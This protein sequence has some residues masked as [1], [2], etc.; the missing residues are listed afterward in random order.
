M[1]LA[2]VLAGI[3]LGATAVAG[4]AW[5]APAATPSPVPSLSGCAIPYGPCYI[6]LSTPSGSHGNRVTVSGVGYYP[7]D[8]V[9]I[10]FWSG[11]PHAPAKDLGIGTTGST[12]SF[13]SR[14]SIPSDPVGSY[15]IFAIDAQGDNQSAPFALTHLIATPSSGLPGSETRVQGHGFLPNETV[16]FRLG[17]KAAS[18]LHACKTNR[19]GNFSGCV[20]T[21]P[22]LTARSTAY[23]LLATDG[24]RI[25]RLSFT[26][27]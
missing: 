20:L 16:T 1:L 6:S 9:S 15:T 27:T 12:G 21:V 23:E 5:A 11:A 14:V 3:A 26:V 19:Y 25:A 18:T 4:S 17:Q 2:I 8:Q 10:Y 22:K 7:G 13:S 24:T